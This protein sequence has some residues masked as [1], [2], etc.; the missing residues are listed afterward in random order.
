MLEC[1]DVNEE[2]EMEEMEKHRSGLV[3]LS[4]MLDADEARPEDPCPREVK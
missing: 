4:K 2:F 3:R 1:L